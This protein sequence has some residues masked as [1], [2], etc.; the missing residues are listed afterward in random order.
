MYLL[1]VQPIPD[2]VGIAGR[3]LKH[4]K[5]T[6]LFEG[7]QLG[8][9]N[10]IRDSGRM[11]SKDRFIILALHDKCW[12]SHRLDQSQ[13]VWLVRELHSRNVADE[14]FESVRCRRHAG[15]VLG[16]PADI[17]T[18]DLVCLDRG[19]DACKRHIAGMCEMAG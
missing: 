16:H 14:D 11:F 8:S 13:P 10:C 9:G 7:Q 5:M 4:R 18:K 15:V 3:V 19:V 17:A 1:L 6:D 12:N 2:R